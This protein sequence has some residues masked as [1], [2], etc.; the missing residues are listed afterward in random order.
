MNV[1]EHFF[2]PS[3]SETSGGDHDLSMKNQ[4][5]KRGH[6]GN[7][8]NNGRKKAYSTSA[9]GRPQRASIM[10]FNQ[11]SSNNSSN[12]NDNNN[13]N[14]ASGSNKKSM[15]RYDRTMKKGLSPEYFIQLLKDCHIRDLDESQVQ[16]L[17]V[18]LRSVKAR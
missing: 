12:N 16:D 18:C 10:S 4:N 3:T 9:R 6:N 8:I 5:N 17:R 14:S 1:Q 7:S 11:D 2:T 13:G 15:H